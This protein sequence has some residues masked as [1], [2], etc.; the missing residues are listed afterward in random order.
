MSFTGGCQCGGV[1]FRAEEFGE[2]I[3]CHCRMCQKATG[4]PF[5]VTADVVD[6]VWTRGAPS[7]FQSSDRAKRGFCAACGTPLTFESG[8][9]VN[10]TVGAFDEAPKIVPTVQ[11]CLESKLAWTDD[12]PSLP[13]RSAEET[14]RLAPVYAAVRSRQ[15]PDHD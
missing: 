9:Y 11:I 10:I 13:Q 4:G 3:V 8:D 7:H 5:A 14:A 12:A 6:L 15:H 2:V 1:R